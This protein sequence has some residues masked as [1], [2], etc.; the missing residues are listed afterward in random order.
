MKLI[1][2]A[3]S[4]KTEWI[5]LDGNTVKG[6]LYTQGFNPNYSDRQELE[7]MLSS[8]ETRFI[9]SP[10]ETIREVNYYGTGC[11][12]QQNCQLVEA[13]LAQHFPQAEIHVTHDLMAVCHAVLGHEKGIA[14]ILGTGSNS[15]VY[16]GE[17]IIE[18]A[19]SLGY[20]L[21]DEGSG[22][23]IGR[24]VLRHYYY[25]FMPDDLCQVFQKTYNLTR[26]EL[27]ENLYHK[28]QPSRYMASFA[29][30]A[31][32]NLAHPYIQDLVKACFAEFVKV[33]VCRYK[34][35]KQLKVSFV[36]SIA[37]HFRDILKDTL[38]DFGLT[39]G[40]VMVTP[41]EGLVRYF[42]ADGHN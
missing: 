7:S 16:D 33:F 37:F 11:G 30:F 28:E 18:R 5:V 2:D 35:C 24:E 19:V 14:C 23:H 15:C 27:V 38:V 42:M 21:G 22:M 25:G 26:D 1:V 17:N 36:G 9:A 39:M 34:D 40:D 32:D 3:G 6:H 20:L 13:A 31:G 4:T 8:V 29:K 41:A 12:S 10:D